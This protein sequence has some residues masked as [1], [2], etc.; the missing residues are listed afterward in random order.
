V[1][2][3]VS[4]A[5]EGEPAILVGNSLGAWLALIQ[6]HRHPETVAR[7]VA[8][9]GGALANDYGD[10]NLAPPDRAAARKLV[11]AL[12]DPASE[13]IPDFVLDDL[14]Q[15]S[16][17]GPAARMM[18]DWE[19]LTAHLLDG[20]LGEI[21]VPVD[22][23]WGESDQL[24]KLD[25]ARRHTDELPRGRLTTIPACGH[26]PHSECPERYLETL[27]SV[28]DQEPPEAR[29]PTPADEAGADAPPGDEAEASATEE[30]A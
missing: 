20:R 26:M 18:L 1:E 9:N 12:R 4:E 17:D 7:V 22:L 30:A 25:Y 2:T 13:E 27:L 10:L 8:L 3:L 19:G 29:E 6:A 5:A 21:A 11:E 28:L 23:V 15:R 16:A 14:V 24:M